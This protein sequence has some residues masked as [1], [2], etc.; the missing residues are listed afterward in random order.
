MVVTLN[1]N[2]SY[3][4]YLLSTRDAAANT[5]LDNVYTTNFTV[6]I[7]T[8]DTYTLAVQSAD[9]FFGIPLPSLQNNVNLQQNN[10]WG[11]PFDPLK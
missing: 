4:D 7:Q 6:S 1:N 10:T 5:S 3:T 8:Q 2:N 11:G 9:Y